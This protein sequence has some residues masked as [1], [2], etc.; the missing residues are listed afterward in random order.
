MQGWMVTF[1]E[2][3]V[4][5]VVVTLNQNMMKGTVR[6]TT[7]SPRPSNTYLTLL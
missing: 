1:K 6:H 3:L 7:I 4:G 5:A 2:A